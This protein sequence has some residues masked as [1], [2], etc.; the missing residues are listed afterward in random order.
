VANG[1]L[2][3]IVWAGIV[4]GRNAMFN[5]T[6]TLVVLFILM[7]LLSLSVAA[8]R[9]YGKKELAKQNHDQL[10]VVMVA[11]GAVF[12]LLALLIAFSFS[13]AFER[14]E[15]RKLHVINEANVI[16]V[17][18]KGIDMMAP[19]A[20]P[21]L[22]ASF[23]EYLDAQLQFY[24]LARYATNTNFFNEAIAISKGIENKI[25]SQALSACKLTHDPIATQLFIPDITNM[26]DIE[27]TGMEI[28][29][30]HPPAAIFGLL[31]GLAIL[32]GFLAG[33]TTANSK[34]KF[35][36]HILS[37]ILITAFTVYIIIDLEFPRIGLIRVDAFDQILQNIRG[38]MR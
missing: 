3:H 30:V 9:W 6:V 38:Q 26:F 35:S 16:N 7:I 36:L 2:Y 8:G 29:R 28:T 4:S 34:T 18:Y 12:T 31:I 17:A 11:E 20:Q 25:W 23:R 14:F 24:K 15:N 19:A 13:G 5:F 1:G 10:E 22:R 21:A 37:Y 32:S 33:Y 27:S